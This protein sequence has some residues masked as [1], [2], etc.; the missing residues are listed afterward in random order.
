LSGLQNDLVRE[1]LAQSLIAWRLDG[2]VRREGNGSIV[3]CANHK[4]IRIDRAGDDLMFRWFVTVEGRKRYAI[5][6]IAVL[7]Q[8][9]Q[10]L[11]PGYAASRARVAA[12]RLA[13]L[14]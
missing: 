8:V 10:A 11:D 7:R 9:R 1:L 13:P 4:E 12:S 6:L 3:I 14:R 5:S 2:S